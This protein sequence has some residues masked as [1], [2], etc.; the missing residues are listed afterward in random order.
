MRLEP[1][2]IEAIVDALVPRMVDALDRRFQEQPQWAFSVAEAAAWCNVPENAVRHAMRV[3]K[4]PYVRLG[5]NIRILRRDL[6]GVRQGSREG[7]E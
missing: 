7:G 1:E 4:L 3:G 2:E 6:F 5:N